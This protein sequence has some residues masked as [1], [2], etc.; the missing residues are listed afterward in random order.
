[1]ITK[2]DKIFVAGSTGMVG[3]SIYELL[4][5][6]NFR[7]INSAKRIDFKNKNKVNVF[8]KKNKPTIII[9]AA[10][11]VGGIYENNKFPVKF[12]RDNLEIQ[13]NLINL[14]FQN[15]IKKIIFLGSSCVYPKKN[16]LINESDLLSGSLEITNIWYAV[17]K[18]SGIKLCQAYNK[19]HKTDYRCIMPT[20]LFG[21]YDNFKGINAHV[22]PSLIQKFYRA[23]SN[24][25][26]QVKIWGSGNAKREFLYVDDLSKLI[27]EI[28]KISRNKYLSNTDNSGIINVGS[29]FE[30]SIKTIA[31]KLK[32]ISSY[33]GKIVFD[34]NS[35]EG[36]KRKKLNL[37]NLNKIV[38]NFK[39]TDFDESLDIVYSKFVN[40]LK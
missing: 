31:E 30:F 1:M 20:N 5:K 21:K 16:S 28:M 33:K 6:K 39:Y 12:L 27:Y 36:V 34:I 23:K 14:A 19:E 25:L 24:N 8:I 13:N 40:S 3:R 10:A 38:K 37:K 2:K 15:G 4:Q 32:K 17:A 9:I 18:I 26:K 22:I 29:N 35:L 7:L 11:V